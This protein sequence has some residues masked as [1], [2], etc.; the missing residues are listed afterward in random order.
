[1]TM[2][3]MMIIIIIIIIAGTTVAPFWAAYGRRFLGSR[4]VDSLRP[5]DATN[6]TQQW[7]HRSSD[8]ASSRRYCGHLWWWWWRFDSRRGRTS[9]VDTDGYLRPQP[10]VDYI[11]S[12]Q[13]NSA[14]LSSSSPTTSNTT[15]TDSSSS[16]EYCYVMPPVTQHRPHPPDSDW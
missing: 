13:A 4:R 14:S 9:N 1:M 10:S 6:S 15:F 7:R 5:P 8:A 12:H 2:M 11:K 16:P 3:M